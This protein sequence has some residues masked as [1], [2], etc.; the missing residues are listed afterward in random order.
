MLRSLSRCPHLLLEIASTPSLS[1]IPAASFL[2]SAPVTHHVTSRPLSCRTVCSSRASAWSV[3]FATV[4]AEPGTCRPHHV[5]GDVSK[6]ILNDWP[7]RPWTVAITFVCSHLPPACRHFIS[8]WGTGLNMPPAARLGAGRQSLCHRSV[9]SHAARVTVFVDVASP[10]CTLDTGGTL[11]A[12]GRGRLGGR[13]APGP[14]SV[15]G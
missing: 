6:Y 11:A 12:A 2:L 14:G 15:R 1:T 8:H 7:M 5:G 4:S 10:S 3:L 9:C 13:P